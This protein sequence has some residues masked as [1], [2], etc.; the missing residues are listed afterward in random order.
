[1][2]IEV[3]SLAAYSNSGKTTFLEKLIPELKRLGL[4]V[5]VV[6]HD[7]HDFELDRE[8]KDTWRITRA[9]A[10][11]TAIVSKNKAAIMENRPV[12]LEDM[13]KKIDN[14]D[15][16]IIEGGKHTE[17]KKILFYRAAAGK[18]PA[19]EAKDCFAVVSDVPLD[20]PAPRFSIDDSAG[21]AELIAADSKK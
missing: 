19:A 2:D 7:G 6:K 17:F 13:V 9:G 11:V 4:R 12:E 18:P 14:V 1:M 16:I 21:L 3:Y 15:V 5:A 8:G 20:T 10:D